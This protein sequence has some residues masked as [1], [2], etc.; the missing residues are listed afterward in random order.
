MTFVGTAE[1]ISPEVIGDRPA[2]YGTDIWAFGVMLYQM[3]FNH[4]PFKAVSAYLTFRNIEKPQINFP[5]NDN[6]PESAKDLIKKILVVDPK[7]RLGGGVSGTPYD[8]ASLKKHPFFDKI[9][10]N[11]LNNVNP[12]GIKDLKFFKP[13]NPSNNSSINSSINKNWEII[14]DRY[15]FEISPNE[16]N[17]NSNAK[18]IKEGTIKKKS[19]LFRY[20]KKRIIL[21]STPR[22]VLIS[23]NDPNH[24][25]EIPLNKKCKIT[26]VENNYFDLKTPVK[27]YRFKGVNNDGNDWAGIIADVI[28]A[29]G[30]E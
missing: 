20:D 15:S 3:Y 16:L 22:L 12:P 21:D 9:K 26:I 19:M 6:I 27:T 25:K 23:V 28:E 14:N 24:I 2:E 7:Q 10:W 30:R 18:V 11:G 8:M 4:T 13:K 17:R 1:Y 5:D 29:Y